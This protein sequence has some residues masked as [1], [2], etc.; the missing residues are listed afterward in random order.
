MSDVHITVN[1][2]SPRF[3][4][5]EECNTLLTH[6]KFKAC[7]RHMERY[8]LCLTVVRAIVER[9]KVSPIH[10]VGRYSP[11]D[12]AIDMVMKKVN[13]RGWIPWGGVDVEDIHLMRRLVEKGDFM[14]CEMAE[15]LLRDN[16]FP[17]D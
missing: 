4:P 8:D 11:M 7:R 10:G 17:R 14:S 3:C 1:G 6:P 12:I 13:G 16:E 15:G 5:F 2:R 9:H